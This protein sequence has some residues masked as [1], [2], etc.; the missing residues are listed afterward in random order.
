MPRGSKPGERR[1]GRQKGTPNKI[2][3][4]VRALAQEYGEDAIRELATILTTSEN[5]SARISA[6]KELLDRGYGKSMQAVEL[7]GADGG[8]LE[9]ITRVELVALDDDSQD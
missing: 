1:G 9:T 6:A 8:P 7:T 2:T 5:H 4:D 3:A